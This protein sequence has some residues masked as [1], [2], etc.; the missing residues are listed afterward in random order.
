MVQTD[1]IRCAVIGYGTAFNQGRHHAQQI[2]DTDGMRLTAV[3]D[4]DPAC[5]AA[6]RQ[7]FPGVAGFTDVDQLLSAAVADLA[8]VVLPH[9][10]HAPVAEACLT[11]GLDV[12]LEKPMALTVDEC[13][14]LITLARERQRMLTVYHNRRWDG[15]FLTLRQIIQEGTVGQVFQIEYFTG[16]YSHP[17]TSWRANKEV[18]GGAFFDWG[19]HVVDWVLGLMEGRRMDAVTGFFHQLVW[20]EVS[21]EDQVQAVIRF[22]D[23]AVADIQQSYIALADKARWRILGTEGALV[24][25]GEPGKNPQCRLRVLHGGHPADIV[26]PYAE[27]VRGTFYPR[28]YT[29]LTRGAPLDV[30]PES[31][32]RVIAVLEGAE[33]SSASGR[34]VTIPFE[35]TVVFPHCRT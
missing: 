15:D 10:L 2:A 25:V 1:A 13:T 14:R 17:G 24:A 20:Q 11:A 34:A 28:L 35:D 31:A 8:V 22:A 19:A 30:T 3:C 18:S 6:G 12:V 4:I 26:V 29:H 27:T 33:Q 7:D 16:G 32:R 21:N 23:G 5:V 9:H